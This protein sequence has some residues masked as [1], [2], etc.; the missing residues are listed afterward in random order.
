MTLPSQERRNAPQISA[1]IGANRESSA[2]T[3]ADMNTDRNY[4]KE[5]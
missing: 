4:E 3:E 2:P 1:W 5:A